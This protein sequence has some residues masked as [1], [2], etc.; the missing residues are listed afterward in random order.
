[1]NDDNDS[2]QIVPG[3]AAVLLLAALVIV[4]GIF[5]DLLRLV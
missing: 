3:D 1:M 5:R 4:C 2:F